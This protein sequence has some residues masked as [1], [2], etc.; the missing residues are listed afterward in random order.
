M[1]AGLLPAARTLID[2]CRHKPRR[3]LIIQKDMID[4]EACVLL[5][6]VTPIFPEAVDT[7]VRVKMRQRIGPTLL[8]QPRMRIYFPTGL[9][10]NKSL[11]SAP[12][13]PFRNRPVQGIQKLGNYPALQR[14]IVAS[15]EGSSGRFV[16]RIVAEDRKFDHGLDQGLLSPIVVHHAALVIP[17]S[18]ATPSNV[19]RVAPTPRDD[20]LGCV[21]NVVLIDTLL[22]THW[23]CPFISDQSDINGQGQWVDVPMIVADERA[24]VKGSFVDRP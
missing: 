9:R 22:A 19:R 17:A 10:G 4:P 5:E 8:K 11:L 2:L 16:E 20:S 14:R 15:C 1:V 21:E 24:I 3:G 23:P 7:L 12:N 6:R 13:Q 18:W